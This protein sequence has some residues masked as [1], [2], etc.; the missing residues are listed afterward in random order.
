MSSNYEVIY[1]TPGYSFCFQTA[2]SRKFH[3]YWHHHIEYEFIVS[4]NGSGEAH[5][6]NI[7]HSFNNPA[8]FFIA[9][10]LDHDFISKGQFDGWIIQI[11]P[12]I[13][14]NYLNRPEFHFMAEL[15]NKSSPALGFSEEV[16]EKIVEILQ[17]A[18]DQEGVFRW[19][20]L[21]EALYL[22][23][24]DRGARLFSFLTAVPPKLQEA[25]NLGHSFLPDSGKLIKNRGDLL[26]EII[27]NIYDKYDEPHRLED[28]ASAAMMPLQSFCRHFKKRTGRTVVEYLHSIRINNAKSLLLQ[29]KFYVDDI[30]YEVGFNSVSF[31]NRKFKEITGMT[32]MEYRRN[33]GDVLSRNR[34][35]T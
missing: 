21:V 27:S 33:F 32:P 20:L 8:A 18:Q 17:R 19:I 23:S 3:Y 24:Q 12:V 15:I 1:P 6:G 14:D 31:F 16:S 4:Q 30:C 29:S 13:F 34:K 2:N 5:I 25:E 10:R 26:D 22:A 28:L 7:I 11:S 35:K 9:P